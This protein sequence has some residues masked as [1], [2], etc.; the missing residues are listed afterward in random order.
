MADLGFFRGSDFG[1]PGRAK[2]ASIEV[3]WAYERMKFERL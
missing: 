1:N 3:V 2:Q